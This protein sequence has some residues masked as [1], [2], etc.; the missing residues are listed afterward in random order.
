MVSWILAL[1]FLTF[2]I[3]QVQVWQNLERQAGA[4][5]HNQT[6]YHQTIT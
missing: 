5:N 1:G 4:T 3:T 2:E 6:K